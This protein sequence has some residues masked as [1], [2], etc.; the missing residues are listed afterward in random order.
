MSEE[1]YLQIAD[2]SAPDAKAAIYELV[3]RLRRIER[4]MRIASGEEARARRARVDLTAR[5]LFAQHLFRRNEP[6]L[7][8]AEGAYIAAALLEQARETFFAAE[9]EETEKST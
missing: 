3:S 9:T 1:R 4:T 8:S 5:A 7:D 2:A 6:L